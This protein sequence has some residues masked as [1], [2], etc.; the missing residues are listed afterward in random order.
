MVKECSKIN[1]E[2]VEFQGETGDMGGLLKE[3]MALVNAKAP[4]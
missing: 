3:W 1:E 2:I 4:I